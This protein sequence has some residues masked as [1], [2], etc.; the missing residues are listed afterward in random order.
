MQS[1]ENIKFNNNLVI[2][3][4]FL[5]LDMMCLIRFSISSKLPDLKH[6]HETCTAVHC[7]V[8]PPY[9]G[10]VPVFLLLALEGHEY[11]P[12]RTLSFNPVKDNQTA[13]CMGPRLILE[14]IK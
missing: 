14:A 9:G 1:V 7:K 4:Q 12:S 8:R 2:T 10:I 11:F 5:H 6:C 13:F 3:N